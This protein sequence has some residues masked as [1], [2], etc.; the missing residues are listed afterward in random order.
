MVMAWN[1]MEL[2]GGAYPGKAGRGT[3]RYGKALAF[4]D[5]VHGDVVRGDAL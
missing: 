2:N 1:C 3:V 5:E 4:V